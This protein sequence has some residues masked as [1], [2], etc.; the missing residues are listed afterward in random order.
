MD[1]TNKPTAP[2]LQN[3]KL[4]TNHAVDAKVVEST[5]AAHASTA[6]GYMR[7]VTR[8]VYIPLQKEHYVQLIDMYATLLMVS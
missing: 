1:I 7:L 2:I 3:Y 4:N 8:H 6:A 5:L